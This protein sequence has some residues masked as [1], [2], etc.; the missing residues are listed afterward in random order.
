MGDVV[1]NDLARLNDNG[2]FAD[3]AAYLRTLDATEET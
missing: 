2:T 3:V 1:M